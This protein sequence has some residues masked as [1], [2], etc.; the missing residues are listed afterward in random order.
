M[1]DKDGADHFRGFETYLIFV[2]RTPSFQSFSGNSQT[3][4]SW[5][6]WDAHQLA[7]ERTRRTRSFQPITKF[8]V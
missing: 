4:P 2:N 5:K 1:D 7:M 3:S 8:R 6:V